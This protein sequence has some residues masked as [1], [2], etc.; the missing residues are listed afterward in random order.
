LRKEFHSYKFG[1]VATGA[2]QTGRSS[3]TFE[4]LRKRKQAPELNCSEK[5]GAVATCPPTPGRGIFDLILLV[6]RNIAAEELLTPPV[7]RLPV[8]R[9]K[10]LR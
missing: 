9:L 5:T 4:T 8:R 7:Q 2:I 10:D 3:A 6:A 1:F